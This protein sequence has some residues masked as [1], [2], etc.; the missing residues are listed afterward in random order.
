MGSPDRGNVMFLLPSDSRFYLNGWTRYRINQ[1]VEWLWQQFG[2]FKE[3]GA[4]TARHV[5]G[6][7]ITLVIDSND[8]EFA[9]EAEDDFGEWA[10]TPDRCDI[11]GRRDL[12]DYQ[13]FNVQQFLYR[14]EA[15]AA[16]V[17]NPRWK[18][19]PAFQVFDSQEVVSPE[20]TEEDVVDGVKVGKFGEALKYFV[21]SCGEE[22]T[23]IPA[24]QMM[25]WFRAHVANQVRGISEFAQAVNPLVDIHEIRQMVN[26]NIKA[27]QL[28][29]MI[30]KGVEKKRGRGAVGAIKNA[31]AQ[32]KATA[33]GDTAQMESIYGAAGAGIAYLD[34]NGEVK[35]IE[36]N[37]PG[38]NL[39]E[40]MTHF[41]LRDVCL[42]P[43]VPM[44]FFWN[45]NEVGG[46]NTR[47]ILSKADLFFQILADDDT[48]RMCTPLAYRYLQWRIKNKKLRK[49]K[50]PN[51]RISWQF[52]RRIT[53]D[54][55]NDHAARLAN[56]AA[57][58]T[59]LKDEYG[60]QGKNWI[61][62]TRQW[63]NEPIKFLEMAKDQLAQSGLPPEM[64]EIMLQR[65]AQNLPLWRVGMP[66]ATG[67]AAP[68]A[69]EDDTPGKTKKD[70]K[71]AAPSTPPPKPADEPKKK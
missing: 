36:P 50:D 4:G 26:R 12:Y 48:S 53:T 71:P 5:V 30:L 16:H 44:E 69:P 55:G 19:A 21:Q 52:P 23:P 6:K 13:N 35:L 25:H 47:F 32:D 59:T 10:R 70:N 24:S 33:T 22:I 31:C 54:N 62:Q 49:P 58:A 57:G 28:L 17:D 56:L 34:E 46:A 61:Q 65:W 3:I 68:A 43:G 37:S 66:G 8:H 18:G 41:L 14:G 39:E 29:G 64:Q 15:F 42:A 27:K 45:I 40:W 7:G 1:K 63:I 2:L 9:Q 20:T 67:G 51:W 60:D 11:A 38:P